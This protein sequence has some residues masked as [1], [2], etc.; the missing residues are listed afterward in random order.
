MRWSLCLALGLGAL[1]TAA[2]PACAQATAEGAARL[3]AALEAWQPSLGQVAPKDIDAV[4]NNLSIPASVSDW[5]VTP[6]GA[7]YRIEVP[8]FRVALNGSDIFFACDAE[9]LLAT[10][11]PDGIFALGSDRLL[12]CRVTGMGARPMQLR[13]KRRSV[14]GSVDPGRRTTMTVTLDEVTIFTDGQYAPPTID[15]LEFTRSATRGEGSRSDFHW[16]V[17]V[18]GL[19]IPLPENGGDVLAKRID[20]GSD[21]PDADGAA[22]IA[23]S[24]ALVQGTREGRLAGADDAERLALQDRLLASLG[25]KGSST[26][27]AEGMEGRRNGV[28]LTVGSLGTGLAYDKLTQAGAEMTLRLQADGITT[29]PKWRY[30]AW[31]PTT[32]VIQVSIS[33]VPLWQ[34]FIGELHG[35]M[36]EVEEDR[37]FRDAR[38]RFAFD[39][40]HLAAPEAVLD[41]AGAVAFDADAAPSGTLRMRLTGI[42]GLVK[43]LQ[44]DPKASEAAAGLSVLQVLGRQTTLPDGRSARDYE[45]VIDPSGKLLVNG[46]DVRSLIPKDL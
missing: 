12:A 36:T 46:A 43:A 24:V 35:A 38:M 19:A 41:F 5:R 15:R 23:S 18:E 39:T 37:L 13:A 33:N 1:T 17:A 26:L 30:N 22:M 7:A 44:A 40:M 6:D 2:G 20:F 28:T 4:V 27:T 3:Q 45:I 10:P 34:A 25:P 21:L 42:D 31:I 16:R 14:A 9:R 11:V 8:G 32:G 29:D